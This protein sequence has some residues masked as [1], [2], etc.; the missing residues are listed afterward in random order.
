M[1]ATHHLGDTISASAVAIA[2]REEAE[3]LQDGDEQRAQANRAGTPYAA[4]QAAKY[5]AR[6]A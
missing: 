1:K 5:D 2:S 4:A 6:C 3:Q